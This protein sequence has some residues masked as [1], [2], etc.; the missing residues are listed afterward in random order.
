MQGNDEEAQIEG[1]LLYR[2]PPNAPF[3]IRDDIPSLLGYDTD[4]HE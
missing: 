2:L 1:N 3:E 4:S